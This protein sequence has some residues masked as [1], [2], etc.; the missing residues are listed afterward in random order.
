MLWTEIPIESVP[1]VTMLPLF[2]T[3][4]VSPFPPAPP[5]PPT[6]T[7]MLS[8]PPFAVATPPPATPPP[9]PTLCA[10]TASAPSP[11]VVIAPLLVKPTIPESPPVPPV[12]P[13]ATDVPKLNFASPDEAVASPP[14]PVPPP[15]PTLCAKTP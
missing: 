2:V 14:P 6:P 7:A 12:P 10:N 9:P 8:L 11:R 4:A 3:V 15:P 1:R 5:L 13:T